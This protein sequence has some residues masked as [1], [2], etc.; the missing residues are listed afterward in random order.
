MP[1]LTARTLVVAGV[2]NASGQG[3]AVDIGPDTTLDLLLTV[4]AIDAGQTLSVF[5]ETG[6]DGTLWSEVIPKADDGNAAKFAAVSAPGSQLVVFPECDRFVRVRWT[7]SG[8]SATFGVTGNSVRVYAKPSDMHRLGLHESYLP[9]ISSRKFDAAIREQTDITD[10]AVGMH[11]VVPLTTWGDDIRGGV[12]ACA[13]ASFLA[14]DG[15]RPGQDE[16]VAARCKEYD[17]W[18]DLV[19]QGKRKPAGAVDQT[20]TVDEGGGYAVSDGRRGW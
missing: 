7:L 1:K 9:R 6:P 3:A 8:G 2:Q 11:Y 5:V 14:I 17:D 4:T 20:P 10:S 12:V 15:N 16:L 13:A 18:L 19:A